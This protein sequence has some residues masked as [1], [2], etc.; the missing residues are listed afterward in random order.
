MECYSKL[1]CK[2]KCMC[3]F[4]L[5]MLSVLLLF[6]VFAFQTSDMRYL[7][8]PL[9]CSRFRNSVGWVQSDGH[10]VRCW[11]PSRS[12]T[13][14]YALTRS[15]QTVGAVRNVVHVFSPT[16]G[17]QLSRMHA[18]NEWRISD[19]C[20]KGTRMVTCDDLGGLLLWKLSE[21]R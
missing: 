7:G 3:V 17:K 21:K 18:P 1:R 12:F 6:I 14:H 9:H 11:N 10:K 8:R 5:N 20:F 2:C 13:L 19:L 4:L 15:N 16:T